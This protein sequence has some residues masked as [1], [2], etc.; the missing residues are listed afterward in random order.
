MSV[1]A[2]F[3]PRSI[4]VY[5]ARLGWAKNIGA[6]D[7]PQA[8]YLSGTENLRGYR[9]NRF[10][11]REM[12][13]NNLELRIRLAE[14][15]TYLFPG[16]LGLLFFN[17]VGLVWVDPEE[18]RRW[19]HGYGAGIWIA[20]IK[21]WVVTASVARSREESLLPYVSVGFRF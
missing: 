16:S 21:R 1:F 11:G 9:R 7:I 6:Y 5:A 10:A 18:S 13:Y 15:S 17:D 20:P 14:F 3:T 19:H 2:S 4:A 8:Q 12:L